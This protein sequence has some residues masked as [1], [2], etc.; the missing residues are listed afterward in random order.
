MKNNFINFL[1]LTK[2]IDTTVKI[3]VFYKYKQNGHFTTEFFV[4][5]FLRNGF[6]YNKTSQS[7]F[8]NLHVTCKL[9]S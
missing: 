7:S 3:V 1:T 8:Q 9:F 2:I 5:N 6:Q 4:R